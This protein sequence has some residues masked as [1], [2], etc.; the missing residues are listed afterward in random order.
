MTD[1]NENDALITREF[2][3]TQAGQKYLSYLE[4]VKSEG[5]TFETVSLNCKYQDGI[6]FARNTLKWC[7]EFVQR[8]TVEST[9]TIDFNEK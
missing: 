7:A 3:E 8:R 6:D 2:L 4:R 1:W 9:Q 5:N